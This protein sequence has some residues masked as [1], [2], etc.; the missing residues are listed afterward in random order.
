M[1]KR[2]GRT[3]GAAAA[4]AVSLLAAPAIADNPVLSGEYGWED[5]EGT[6][7]GFFNDVSNPINTGPIDGINPHSGDRMLR[8]T[9]ADGES[10]TP[11]VYVA[12]IEHLQ[13]GDVIRAS[14]HG[15][16][17]TPGENPRMRIWSHYAVSGDPQSFAGSPPLAQQNQQYTSGIGWEQLSHEWTFNSNNG[18]RDA[19]VIEVRLYTNEDDTHFYIDDVEVE[20]LCAG[21]PDLTITFADF[22]PIGD[23]DEPGPE[24]EPDRPCVPQPLGSFG[25][26]D[27]VSTAFNTTGNI[28]E[29]QNTGEINGVLPYAGDR[30][31]YL[32]QG[33]PSGTPQAWV[34]FIENL[35]DGDEVNVSMFA[36][37]DEP[38]GNPGTRICAHGAIS[39]DP[40]SV[41]NQFGG[42]NQT[43]TS[44]IGWEQLNETWVF[45]SLGGQRDAMM[46]QVRLYASGEDNE[47]YVDE[48]SVEV[49]S[50]NPNVS[51]TFPD[52]IKPPVDRCEVPDDSPTLS[53]SFGWEDGESTILGFDDAPDNITSANVTAPEPVNSGDHALRVTEAPH[54]GTVPKIFLAYIEHLED[55][56]VIFG[57]FNTY[58]D[59]PD[60]TPRV[61][62]WGRR[63]FSGDVNSFS[64][65]L[66]GNEEYSA[67]IGW[68]ELCHTWVFDSGPQ[69][70]DAMVIEARIY[71]AD[72]NC[73][74]CST[75]YYFDDIEVQIW[76]GPNAT[77][78]FPDGVV[79][80]DPPLICPADINNSG[81]VDT[82]DLFTVLG[83][84]GTSDPDADINNDGTVDGLDLGILLASWGAC[85][86]PYL[87]PAI[88]E[89]DLVVETVALR[90]GM[91]QHEIYVQL[92]DPNDAL[93]NVYDANVNFSGSFDASSYIAIGQQSL[94]VIPD[95]NF[96]TFEFDFGIGM[97]ENAG[98]YNEDPDNDLGLAGSY[99]NNRVL[100]AS[101]TMDPAES[102]EGT[103]S[104]TYNDAEG[105]PIYAT[106]SFDTTEP[107]DTCTG[108]LNGDGV[109][110]VSDLLQLLG[111]WG[112]C[113]GCDADFNDDG[114]VDVSDLLLLLGNWGSCD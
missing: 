27:E 47:F 37:D 109:V 95:P 86:E 67:G 55:G 112:S 24:C 93:V 107:A 77:I 94:Q 99:P 34:A 23:P 49:C 81:T 40:S 61:R 1:Y 70:R 101:L 16:D 72:P 68:E 10:D 20:V 32:K 71:S 63:V 18:Q 6:I 22:D 42:Q 113:P 31:L 38:D 69:D 110:D 48:I 7:V 103:L 50:D 106:A 54:G 19:F 89:V 98:W 2:F 3:T 11:Q 111:N 64:Q 96:D 4:C 76:A 57:R 74:E 29:I 104:V 58:D 66:G 62:I 73:E 25:W 14:F 59:V 92:D 60:S 65:S 87:R 43:F 114:V 52:D 83:A 108:D 35:E 91:N 13:D 44:G 33:S 21:N 5:G 8:V 79:I 90:S 53:G 100:I 105:R 84:W 41:V 36:Y 17:D 97:G 80:G 30:M 15:Y 88:G 51:V 26:E 39:G 102:A 75:D 12:Y 82:F 28:V 56:D 9:Q 45:D 78:T 46:I 85:T